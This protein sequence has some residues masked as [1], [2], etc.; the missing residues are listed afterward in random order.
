MD[1]KNESEFASKEAIG[2]WKDVDL[3]IGGTEHADGTL[4]STAVFG[5]S[6]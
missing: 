3:Y 1:P 6:L 4:A 2:Y 5:T